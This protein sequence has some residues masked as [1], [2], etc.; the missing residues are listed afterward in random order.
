EGRRARGHGS[1]TGVAHA[2]RPYPVPARDGLAVRRARRGTAAEPAR[3]RRRVPEL[4][5]PA[6]EAARRRHTRRTHARRGEDPGQA[7]GQPVLTA[8]PMLRAVPATIFVAASRSVVFSSGSLRCA[9]S[10]SCASVT[11]AA[12]SRPGV[13]E[14][15]ATP[16]ARRNRKLVGGVSTRIWY[17]RSSNTVI[18]TGT[19][20]PR[21][22]AVAS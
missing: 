11:L 9:I 2:A 5:G 13:A 6:A 15:D 16:A 1:G 19:R 18:S 20:S 7:P 3:Y 17:D 14:P 22:P 21:C 12:A 8:M 10:R 4:A